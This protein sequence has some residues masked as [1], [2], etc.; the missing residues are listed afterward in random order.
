MNSKVGA[1]AY[2]KHKGAYPDRCHNCPY[3]KYGCFGYLAGDLCVLDDIPG[4]F[5]RKTGGEQ[6]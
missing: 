4:C 2:E 6:C 3:L 5:E 1:Y